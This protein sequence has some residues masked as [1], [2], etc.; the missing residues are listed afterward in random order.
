[1][2]NVPLFS[3]SKWRTTPVLQ[4][5]Q[6]PPEEASAAASGPGCGA[7]GAAVVGAEGE[8]AGP[9]EAKQRIRK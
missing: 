6:E 4:E 7:A 9:V 3:Y 5:G 1:M 2:V 8:A